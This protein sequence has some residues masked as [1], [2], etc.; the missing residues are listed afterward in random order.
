MSGASFIGASKSLSKKKKRESKKKEF[1]KK[2]SMQ[3]EQLFPKTK[4]DASK[5]QTQTQ[6]LSP[7][8]W[9]FRYIRPGF[10]WWPCAH[11]GWGCRCLR[12]RPGSP[13]PSQ[14]AGGPKIDV[15]KKKNNL[16]RNRWRKCKRNTKTPRNFQ[17]SNFTNIHMADCRSLKKTQQQRSEIR[18]FRE[19]QGGHP[20]HGN[21]FKGPWM[22]LTPHPNPGFAG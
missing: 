14:V 8:P 19:A 4:L 13:S 11:A 10:E 2:T 15:V 7:F 9:L 5:L 12:S 17:V 18:A 16:P 22:L 21:H 3:K 6:L 1:S 20:L